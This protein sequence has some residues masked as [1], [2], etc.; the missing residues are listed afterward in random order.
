MQWRDE[1][2]L[3]AMLRAWQAQDPTSKRWISLGD[4]LRLGAPLLRK[5]GRC[6]CATVPTQPTSHI[7]A[8]QAFHSWRECRSLARSQAR[9]R[10]WF[11]VDG[12]GT[13]RKSGKG[14]RV[15]QYILK[16]M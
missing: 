15:L 3:V 11:H 6:A 16:L 13:G 2:G 5:A 8:R 10:K 7:T 9:R 1:Q 4:R 14:M 12:T